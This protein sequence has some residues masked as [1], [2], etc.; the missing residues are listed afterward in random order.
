MQYGNCSVTS[1]SNVTTLN[2]CFPGL[3]MIDTGGPG[4]VA[5]HF[6]ARRATTAPRTAHCQWNCTGCGTVRIDQTNGLPV[7]LLEFSVG[8]S[9]QGENG[10][11]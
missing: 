5:F 10:P 9:E 4:G 7:E 6:R 2:G 1:S 3:T 8:E 11:E